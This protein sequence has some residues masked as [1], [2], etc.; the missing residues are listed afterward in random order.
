MRLL[1]SLQFSAGRNGDEFSLIYLQESKGAYGLLVMAI[2]WVT[3]TV[4]LP[5]TALLPMVI[6]PLLGV[7]EAKDL[8]R[9]YL[10]VRASAGN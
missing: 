10:K 4:P 3:E 6:F 7:A 8:S 9:E 5:V 1:S 2:Y